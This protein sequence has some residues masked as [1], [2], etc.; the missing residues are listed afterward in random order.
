MDSK[1][2]REA[3]VGGLR[4]M[5]SWWPET[6]QKLKALCQREQPDFILTD[7][8]A[9]ASV[10][11]ARELQIPMA[12]HY[13]QMPAQMFPH[14][15]IPGLPGFQLKHLTSENA[16]LWDRM[17]EEVSKVQFIFAAKNYFRERRKMRTA[18]GVA[19][20]LP[21]AKPDYVVLVNSFFGLE[22][23][24]DLPPLALPIG[25]VLAD[26]FADFG[27]ASELLSF[28]EQRR[29]VLYVAFGSHL[30]TPDWR[31][32]RLVE[33]IGAAMQTGHIDGVIW[34]MKVVKQETGEAG[35]ALS[36]LCSDIVHGRNPDWKIAHWVPQRAILSHPSTCMYLSHCG[37]SSTMEAVFHG[38]PVIAMPIYADQLGNGKRLVAAGVGLAAHKD[39][40][41][42]AEL[43]GK[44][45]EMVD[46][47]KGDFAR[48]VLRLRR[49]A[50]ANSQRKHLAAQKI[51]EVLYD[52]EL[53]HGS[54]ADGG[55]SSSGGGGARKR[56]L[57]PMHLQ[58]CD[59]RMS[60]WRRNNVDLWLAFPLCTPAILVSLLAGAWK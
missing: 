26:D 4:F 60:W 44:I 32:R 40:F 31:F 47:E 55:G 19:S 48:N 5:M 25:P 6:Y 1:H 49:I 10:D 13:P 43:Q 12:A 14:S 39:N 18:L 56:E 34:A 54:C 33:G 28:L 45:A 17:H 30:V 52:H 23:A 51:E 3:M 9:D 24:Q 59:V 41:T 46:D 57:R 7:L 22:P 53:R 8:L 16:S 2:G 20:A 11:I 50:H 35:D 38:V 36:A 42:A 27:K 29:R 58:T 15:Y 21:P 37:A